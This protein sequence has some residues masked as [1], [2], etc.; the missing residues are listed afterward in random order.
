MHWIVVQVSN[1][2]DKI[3]KVLSECLEP[4]SQWA[5]V[6][7][8]EKAQGKEL[9]PERYEDAEEEEEE[10]RYLGKDHIVQGFKYFA[11]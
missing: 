2:R 7:K 10:S 4:G 6:G 9:L 1:K 11:K 5:E 3:V 8:C